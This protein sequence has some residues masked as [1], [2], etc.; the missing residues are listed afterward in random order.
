MYNLLWYRKSY[1]KTSGRLWR[2]YR[3]KSNS[4]LGGNDININY[5]IKGS[6]SFRYKTNITGKL[7]GKT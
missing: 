3:A 4:G 2:Y 5:S 7:E 6:K 1:S